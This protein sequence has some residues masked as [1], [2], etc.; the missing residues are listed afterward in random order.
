M[1]TPPFWLGLLGGGLASFG[2][3]RAWLPRPPTP[4]PD[5]LLD[6]VSDAVIRCDGAGR[7][8]P[9]NAAARALGCG[10]TPVDLPLHYPSGQPVPPGQMP[11]ARAR[12]S[13]Q[14]VAC[15]GYLLTTPDGAA[16]VVDVEAHPL[17][18]GGAAAVL[19]DV[20][21]SAASLA[22]EAR[23][24]SRARVLD[25]LARRL[26]AA[27]G[28]D[29]AARAAVE[30]ALALLDGLPGAR[31][32]LYL[33]D[34]HAGRLTLLAAA[35]EDHPKRPRSQAQAR[36]SDIPFDAAVPWVWAVY[37]AR[38]VYAD[39]DTL[40]LPL[41]AG[42]GT[43]GHLTLG[44]QIGEDMEDEGRRGALT[45]LAAT[46]SLSLAGWHQALRADEMA[47]QAGALRGV[48][49]A[50]ASGAVPDALADLVVGH[51]R[52]LAGAD[53]CTVAWLEAG[54]LRLAGSSFR[55]A[56]LFPEGYAP[57]D[58]ALCGSAARKA[59][60]TGERVMRAGL[61][62]P[63][64]G[65]GPWRALAGQSGAHTVLSLPLAATRGALTVYVLGGLPP[66]DAHVT[67]LESLAA[68]LS[69]F[70]PPATTPEAGTSP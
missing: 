41:L 56:L 62:N 35:P 63:A 39:E 52:R 20:T 24:Q 10:D 13:G 12:R 60:K 8:A 43:L 48:A 29:G 6:L 17:S 28:R 44:A 21:A 38:E 49:R 19:R 68:L 32:R 57:D 59:A 5:P 46:A 69:L 53:L 26:G 4:P 23:A 54:R 30:A 42:G 70:P 67:F 18:G 16:R 51:A 34:P 7:V 3:R 47:A 50:A 25:E 58:P 55:D 15:P 45:L 27:P 66:S 64:F 11:L 14:P 31:A 65:A 33:R 2:T 1:F 37:V 40:I 22:R 61:P 9:A 36:A